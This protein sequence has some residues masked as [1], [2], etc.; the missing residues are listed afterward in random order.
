[1]ADTDVLVSELDSA[2]AINTNDLLLMTQPDGDAQT[3]YASR[4]GTVLQTAT[5]MLKGIEFTTDLPHFTDK[6]VLGALEELSTGKANTSGEYN[7][8]ISGQANAL[9]PSARLENSTPYLFRP[10]FSNGYGYETLIGGTC[11]VNQL[12]NTYRA[13]A[14]YAG[15]TLTNNTT[16]VHLQGLT[17][18]EDNITIT[19]IASDLIPN[20]HRILATLDGI[21]G[22]DFKVVCSTPTL[23]SSQYG[24]FGIIGTAGSSLINIAVG[25]KSGVNIN[26]DVRANIF[27]LTAYFGTTIADYV[28]TLE[29]GT[30]GAGITWLK[31]NGFFNEAYYPYGASSLLSVKT[32]KK[33]NR[34]ADNNIIG[35]YTLDGSRKVHR[36][37]GVVTFN[38]TEDWQDNGG[39]GV[40]LYL[41][42]IS[43]SKAGGEF[44]CR[45]VRVATGQAPTQNMTINYNYPPTAIQIRV[46]SAL[47]PADFKTWLQNNPMEFIYELETP[48]DETV[49][50]P[51]LRG[52]LKLD[53]NN[54]LYY[55]GDTCN[56]FTNPM[57]VDANGTEQFVDG[58]TVE[59]PVGH[60][61]I[62]VDDNDA[63][64]L[65]NLP[66]ISNDGNGTYLVTQNNGQMTLDKYPIPNP[67][68]TDGS[69]RL[70]V[71][72]TDGVPA[73]T[74]EVIS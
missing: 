40:Y 43:G 25:F 29:S 69:Y 46:D 65:E 57:V 32:S 3:G 49:N 58:R 36:V 38:G 20:G 56:D 42:G 66:D 59:M 28:Y 41:T 64:K 48:F 22:N 10:S 44:I 7:G 31:N 52:V 74:W 9:K 14:S 34:D 60:S 55:Y 21:S 39:L 18:V 27:D 8:L 26:A 70:E 19:T 5:K 15:I 71:T 33:I 54:N 24:S 11:G 30:S 13:D 62:Y 23:I 47:S 12:V 2:S 61:T 35:E 72:V 63:T 6:T 1:M 4:K 50:N 53:S 17:T 68:T 16:Y 67:P 45:L 73:Y 37:F 51:E